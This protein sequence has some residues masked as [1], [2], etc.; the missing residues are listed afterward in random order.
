[1]RHITY[2]QLHQAIGFQIWEKTFSISVCVCVVLLTHVNESCHTCVYLYE[3]ISFKKLCIW[4]KV[5]F[6]CLYQFLSCGC[7][8]VCVCVYVWVCV[9]VCERK[10]ERESE[11]EREGGRERERVCV[12]KWFWVRLRVFAQLLIIGFVCGMTGLICGNTFFFIVRAIPVMCVCVCVCV[13]LC[14]CS[15]RVWEGERECVSV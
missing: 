10:R 14:V 8:C 7:V 6:H 4:K 11:S 13:C 9:C 12:C 2:V 5:L 3:N 15:W 1:M